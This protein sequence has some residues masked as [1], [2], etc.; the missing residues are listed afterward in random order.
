MPRGS[1][2]KRAT[3]VRHFPMDVPGSPEE[4]DGRLTAQ[5]RRFH[6]RGQATTAWCRPIGP[7]GRARAAV[8]SS[9]PGELVPTA[10][11][12]ATQEDAAMSLDQ[13]SDLDLKPDLR[14]TIAE[15]PRNNRETVRV[16]ID[17]YNDV[18]TIDLRTWVDV[19]G[20][21]KPTRTGLTLAVKHLP[22]L[23]QTL[24]DALAKARE[25][26]LLADDGGGQ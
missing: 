3:T 7:T 13:V 19:Q 6:R 17:R 25:L 5:V 1:L 26:G 24:A 8:L 4:K 11:D 21:L 2:Q 18:E 22:A 16:R 20:A 12:A 14:I 15:W 10:A 23:S 9:S